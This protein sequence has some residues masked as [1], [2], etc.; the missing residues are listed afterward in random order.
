M[1]RKKVSGP[2]HIPLQ[3]KNYTIGWL[4][5][6]EITQLARLEKD[7]FPEP[8]SIGALA[9]LLLKPNTYYL[10]ARKD[11]RVAAYIGFQVF[12]ASAHTISMGVAPGH[13]RAG[14]ARAIQEAANRVAANR[15][16]RWFT[17]EVRAS[18]TAQLDFLRKSGWLE[19]GVCRRFFKNG[20]DAVV[21]WK[22]L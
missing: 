1:Y 13:R 20:E 15:G 5:P 21:V 7:F 9:R 22:W 3:Y 2:D 11:S 16:A 14:L 8:L 6:S 10:T 17:G 18:N 4:R 12:L 19:I